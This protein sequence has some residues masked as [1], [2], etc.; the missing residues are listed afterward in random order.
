V[1]WPPEKKAIDIGDFYADSA[2]IRRTLGWQPTIGLAE[3]FRRTLAYYR[4]HLPHYVPSADS[5]VTAL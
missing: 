4:A 5:P 3:G 1:E 2:R